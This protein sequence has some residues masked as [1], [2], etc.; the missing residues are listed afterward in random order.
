MSPHYGIL[1]RGGVIAFLVLALY[2]LVVATSLIGPLVLI[3]TAG[4][5]VV[6]VLVAVYVT[7]PEGVHRRVLALL[8]WGKARFAA[9]P[10]RQPR[11]RPAMPARGSQ[12]TLYRR[13]ERDEADAGLAK[14]SPLLR[15]LLG[16]GWR[17]PAA[18]TRDFVL[19]G[20]AGLVLLLVGLALPDWPIIAWLG[21]L[22]SLVG[23]LAMLIASGVVY[24]AWHDSR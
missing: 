11:P 17:N 10:R 14:G 24:S 21:K 15:L 7:N 3:V 5:A 1:K 6:A 13:P 8:R 9:R 19:F 23:L 16:R 12:P 18:M 20:L 4:L 2:L 22:L